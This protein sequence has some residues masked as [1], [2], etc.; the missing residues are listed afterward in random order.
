MT[1]HTHT[2]TPK[3][4]EHTD[5]HGGSTHTHTH[6]STEAAL[7]NIAAALPQGWT[8]QQDADLRQQR[9]LLAKTAVRDVVK[10]IQLDEARREQ[11]MDKP[12]SKKEGDK[13]NSKAF[14]HKLLS[15]DQVQCLL[16]KV[17]Q[18]S[19]SV[20]RLPFMSFLRH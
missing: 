4:L 20:G 3:S 15:N 13:S 12:K 1:A 7:G 2:H 9:K 19:S 16:A 6:S 5:Q 18:H 17:G 10:R 8:Q 11:R 14:L